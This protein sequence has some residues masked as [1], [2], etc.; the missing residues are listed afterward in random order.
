MTRTDLTA[1]V[2]VE[3]SKTQRMLPLMPEDEL[4][5]VGAEAAGAVVQEKRR[6]TA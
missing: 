1:H 5:R 4:H 2:A 6:L 3:R